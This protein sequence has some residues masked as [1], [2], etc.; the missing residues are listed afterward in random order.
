MQKY[1]YVYI[2][3]IFAF[4]ISLSNNFT[5]TYTYIYNKYIYKRYTFINNIGL[6]VD[7]FMCQ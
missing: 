4:Q 1:I 2:S 3:P 6:F 7:V 5:K